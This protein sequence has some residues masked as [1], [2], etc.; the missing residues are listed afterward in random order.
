MAARYPL[1]P[2]TQRPHRAW[3]RRCACDL[4]PGELLPADAAPS[5]QPAKH[6][7][8]Y[9]AW[10]NKGIRAN[11]VPPIGAHGPVRRER[12]R[13]LPNRSICALPRQCG[14]FGMAA[15]VVA[16][17]ILSLEGLRRS[18]II[19]D[20][21]MSGVGVWGRAQLCRR[22]PALLALIGSHWVQFAGVETFARGFAAAH[23]SLRA[24]SA[25]RDGRFGT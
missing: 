18:K 6:S 15:Q 14:F 22:A 19:H 5:R 20:Q 3:R 17:V 8:R 9:R 7:R 1:L 16:G 11:A 10:P 4:Q 24:R 21:P 2:P 13:A 12:R 23:K 25:V